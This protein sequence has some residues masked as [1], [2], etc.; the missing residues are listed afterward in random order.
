MARILNRLPVER[1]AHALLWATGLTMTLNLA[2]IFGYAPTEKV[3]GMVQRIFYLHVPLAW[4]GFLGFFLTCGAGAWYL[5]TRLVFWDIVARASAEVGLI[6][7]SLV[8]ITGSLWGRP[9]WGVWWV[10][11]ARLTTTFILWLIFVGYFMLRSFLGESA[12]AARLAAIVGIIGF[13]DIPLI[14][15]SVVWWHT[16]HPAQA[17]LTDEGRSLI[18]PTMMVTLLT[19][20]CAFTLLFTYVVVQ[21]V[22]AHSANQQCRALRRRRRIA[23]V[24][25]ELGAV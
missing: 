24:A 19:S 13:A 14:H 18:T 3:Q 8:L 10:W 22:L 15:F 9:T 16:L 11:D 2:L 23:E 20:L 12:R 25:H 7:T 1:V 6:F 17:V 5:R 21:R 4:V